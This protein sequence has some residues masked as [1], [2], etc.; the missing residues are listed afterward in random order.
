MNPINNQSSWQKQLSN[1]KDTSLSIDSKMIAQAQDIFDCGF[2]LLICAVGGL[3][4]FGS[5]EFTEK[6]KFFMED[7]NKKP[8]E[9][10]KYCCIIHNEDFISAIKLPNTSADVNTKPNGVSK[11]KEILKPKHISILDIL[12]SNKFSKEFVNFLCS[13][14]KFDVFERG[15]IKILLNHAFLVNNKESKA[16]GISLPELL[17]ISLQWTK[18]SILPLEYQVASERQLD[19]VIEALNVVLPTCEKFDGAGALKDYTLLENLNSGSVVIQELAQDLGLPYAKI[20]KKIEALIKGLNE[21]ALCSIISDN[22][23]YGM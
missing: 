18:T 21:Q 5:Q 7:F 4:F 2:M 15:T 14:L 13:C 8:N 6:L 3:E 10:S 23:P 1:I 22:K 20:W 12:T 9:K 19:R 16:T 17:K 11:S